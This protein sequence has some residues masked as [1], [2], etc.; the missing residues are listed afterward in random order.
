MREI[1][2]IAGTTIS[3]FSRSVGGNFKNMLAK[4]D[5][6]PEAIPLIT[7]NHTIITSLLTNIS[8]VIIHY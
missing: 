3:S 2:E 4:F 6:P 5:F 1:D 8:H 7:T